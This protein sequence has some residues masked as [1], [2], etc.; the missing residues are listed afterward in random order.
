MCAYYDLKW[1]Y[2]ERKYLLVCVERYHLS[3]GVPFLGKDENNIFI[4][5]FTHVSSLYSLKIMRVRYY[6]IFTTPVLH[7]KTLWF[8]EIKQLLSLCS[9]GAIIGKEGSDPQVKQQKAFKIAYEE[10]Q[11]DLKKGIIC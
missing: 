7:R 4:G 2:S 5:I 8:K 10:E 11:G 3:F 1:R 6:L 9:W